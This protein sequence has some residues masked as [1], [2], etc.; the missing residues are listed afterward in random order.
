MYSLAYL[1]FYYKNRRPRILICT[2]D[3]NRQIR[4]DLINGKVS[5]FT[6]CEWYLIKRLLTFPGNVL[7]VCPKQNVII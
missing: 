6:I 3:K 1:L 2:P 7:F 5:I 4:Y